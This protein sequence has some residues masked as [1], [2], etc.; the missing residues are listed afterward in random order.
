MSAV[1]AIAFPVPPRTWSAAILRRRSD[2]II[3]HTKNN[4]T[5][6]AVHIRNKRRLGSRP[7]T[8]L[9]SHANA[10]D[11]GLS[12][13]FLDVLSRFCGAD[14]L[15]YE[16]SGYSISSG[17]PSEEGCINC[18]DAALAYLVDECHVPAQRIIA[19]GRSIGSGPTVDL[20]SRTPNLGGMILQSPI[21]SAGLVVLPPSLCKVLASFDLFRN[22]E[23]IDKVRCRTLVI[24]GK[25]DT[26]VPFDHAQML[27]P[28]IRDKHPPL[29][30]E[31]AGHHDMPDDLCLNAVANFVSFVEERAGRVL[32]DR[33]RADLG[34]STSWFFG[35]FTKQGAA[36]A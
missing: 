13:P 35:L 3:L 8:I 9:Y 19:Y 33:A 5:T 26:M 23:K 25:N 28:Q 11:L 12:L 31:G 20:A 15:A 18:I 32:R 30:I 1:N 14:V 7:V 29:W 36:R 27:F 17:E 16:Y 2:L 22:Y 10:E 4:E 24:H 21:A 34:A 6:A